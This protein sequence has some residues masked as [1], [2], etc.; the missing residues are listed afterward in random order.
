VQLPP[1]SCYFIPCRTKYSPHNPVLKHRNHGLSSCNTG[2]RRVTETLKIIKPSEWTLNCSSECLLHQINLSNTGQK[3]GVRLLEHSYI[4][5]SINL[6]TNFMDLCCWEIGNWI[7]W[8]YQRKPR[9]Y[10]K[11]FSHFIR[12][13]YA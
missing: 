10:R 9:L 3:C 8:T 2:R 6:E 1:F 4:T 5:R 7:I 11:S 12:E 13:T